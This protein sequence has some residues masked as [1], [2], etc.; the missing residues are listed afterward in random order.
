M[1]KKTSC[2]STLIFSIQF[3]IFVL[4]KIEKK[5]NKTRTSETTFLL[6]SNTLPLGYLLGLVNIPTLSSH[7]GDN[8]NANM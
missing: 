7:G 4:S 2:I 1:K 3:S 6:L 5:Q 8:A